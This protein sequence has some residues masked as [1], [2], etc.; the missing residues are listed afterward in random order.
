MPEELGS[1][2]DLESPSQ[3]KIVEREWVAERIGWFVLAAFV[4]AALLGLLGPGPLSR[5]RSTSPDKT[6]TVEYY[7]IQR[8]SA[9][10]ELHIHLTALDERE[11]VV[12]LRFKRSFTDHTTIE[13]IVPEPTVTEARGDWIIYSFRM[14]D[15]NP[16][17]LIHFRY[18]HDSFG[19]LKHGLGIVEVD[20]TEGAAVAITQFVLP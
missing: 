6:L 5:C 7:S 8:Y 18:Q 14:S 1:T 13:K 16:G 20:N 2:L 19:F 4:I 17:G 12:R 15:L 3:K 9:P 10:A 11:E